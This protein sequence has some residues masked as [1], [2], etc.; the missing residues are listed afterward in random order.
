MLQVFNTIA[1]GGVWVQPQLVKAVVGPD[2]EEQ[3]PPAPETRRV[4]SAETA[5]QMTAMMQN[6]VSDVGTGVN[7][8]IDGYSVAGKTGTAKKPR[9]DGRGYE[10]GAYY[11]SFAGFVPAQSPRLSTIVVLDEPRPVYYAGLVAAP[12]F[13]RVSQYGLRLFKIPPPSHDLGVSVPA[14]KPTGVDRVD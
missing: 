14:A 3:H 7:A 13:A 4:I 5:K 8:K 9:V 10:I 11:S 12:V 2:G 1:N 6:V